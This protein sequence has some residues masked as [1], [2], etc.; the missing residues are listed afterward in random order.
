MGV[1]N[2]GTHV[3]AGLSSIHSITRFFKPEQ[4]SF[5]M[6]EFVQAS[7]IDRFEKAGALPPKNQPFGS[8]GITAF[9]YANIF[10][11]DNSVP[12]K[13]FGLDF[14]YSAGRTHTKGAMADN[15]RFL[16]SSRIKP[17]GNFGAAFCAPAIKKEDDMFTTPILERYRKLFEDVRDGFM[18]NGGE[19]L[20]QAQ[21]AQMTSKGPQMTSKGAQT[22]KMLCAERETLLELKGILTG[23]KKV[24]EDKIE[25][26]ITRL[27]SEREYLFLHFPDGQK[28]VYTQSFLNRVRVEIEF[29]LKVM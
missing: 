21:G 9:Y 28:F 6:T 18:L 29:Y 16:N 10:K 5:F 15:A 12:L 3:F 8:V 13:T 4:I 17:D 7:F 2:C 27:V 26:E 11:K 20:R 19:A 25:E 1:Q 24:A 14:A 23:Q 22:M